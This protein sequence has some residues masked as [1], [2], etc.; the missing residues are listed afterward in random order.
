MDV[1][2]KKCPFQP[3]RFNSSAAWRAPFHVI[4]RKDDMLSGCWKST[5]DINLGVKTTV[6]QYGP[7]GSKT[8]LVSA[9][10][11]RRPALEAGFRRIVR[12]V[13]V[14]ERSRSWLVLS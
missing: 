13:V 14:I 8:R 6:S 3:R 9:Y 11:Q 4:K 2:R 1:V 10:R 7:N 12:H 5:A